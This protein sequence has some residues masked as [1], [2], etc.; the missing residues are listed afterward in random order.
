ML[1]AIS[2]LLAC[3]ARGWMLVWSFSPGNRSNQRERE[4]ATTTLTSMALLGATRMTLMALPRKSPG[5]PSL[6]MIQWKISGSE[7]PWLPTIKCVQ[8]V[9]N[10]AIAVLEKAPTMASLSNVLPLGPSF[11]LKPNFLLLSCA[12]CS[13]SPIAIVSSES[14]YE[15]LLFSASSA[16]GNFGTT[17]VAALV[18]W[19]SPS[20][21]AMATASML[22]EESPLLL[23]KEEEGGG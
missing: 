10:G 4:R 12:A 16:I 1:F 13:L 2:S 20:S 22:P 23:F 19:R 8:M 17:A 15:P 11:S 14:Y 5:H 9:S 21:S 3:F 7:W 6:V 18:V